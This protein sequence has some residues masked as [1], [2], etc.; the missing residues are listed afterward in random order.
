M[1]NPKLRPCLNRKLSPTAIRSHLLWLL[2]LSFLPVQALAHAAKESYV[3]VNVEAD[4]LAGYFE[5]ATNDLRE[6]LELDLPEDGEG[7]S[8]AVVATAKTV[9]AYLSKHFSLVPIAPGA[10]EPA[11]GERPYALRF[12]GTELV[13]VEGLGR[14][15]RYHY[16]TDEGQ[17]ATRIQVENDLFLE[18]DR[19]HRSL[20]MIA[21]NR[22]TG[23]TFADEFTALIFGPATRRQ[24]LDLNN[25]EGLLRPREFI[26]QGILHIWIGIDH[27]L[28]LAALLLTAVLLRRREAWEP[29]PDFRSACWKVVGIVTAFTIAHSITLTLSALGILRLPSQVVEAAIA[30]SIVLVA[31]NNLFP[32]WNERS[33]LLIF[34]FTLFH[35]MGFASAMGELPFRMVSLVR[36]VLAFNIG[37]ELGV[38]VIVALLFPFLF[39]LRRTTFYRPVILVGGSIVIG[40]LALYW[41]VERAFGL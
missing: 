29:V 5:I 3:W 20:L 26:R 32:K 1:R 37:V 10:E 8:A 21:F 28:F 13:N 15:A 22:Q 33:W 16:R 39:L 9:Q 17:V 2:L 19:F 40:L 12:R 25:I 18:Q 31:L 11:I 34:F 36:V 30:L 6:Q 4:H 23:E 7:E 41:F 35:G 24:E 38:L 14:F 27:V